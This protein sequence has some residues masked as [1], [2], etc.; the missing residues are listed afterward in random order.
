MAG[1]DL[2][3]GFGEGG[4]V[5]GS[6]HFH[7]GFTIGF[8][9]SEAFLLLDVALVTGFAPVGDVYFGDGIWRRKIGGLEFSDD[10]SSGQRVIEAGVDEVAEWFGEFGDFAVGG[11]GVGRRRSEVDGLDVWRRIDLGVHKKISLESFRNL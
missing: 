4:G 2:E 10:F 7:G 8:D 3:R 11:F 9:E 5:V 6:D 1:D